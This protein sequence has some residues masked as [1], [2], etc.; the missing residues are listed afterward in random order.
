VFLEI[1]RYCIN[2]ISRGFKYL[3]YSIY[4]FGEIYASCCTWAE[5]IRGLMGEKGLMEEDWNDRSNWRKK[6]L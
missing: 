1:V 3:L 5:G 6:I 2:T 4:G